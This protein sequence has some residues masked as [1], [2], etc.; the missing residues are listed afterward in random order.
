[1]NT[2]YTQFSR[3]ELV[4]DFGRVTDY[5]PEEEIT[6]SMTRLW[7]EAATSWADEVLTAEVAGLSGDAEGAQLALQ[8][9]GRIERQW[10][11]DPSTRR[12]VSL[13]FHAGFVSDSSL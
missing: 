3:S 6:P 9:A 11:D 13:F 12:I 1:M 8:R 4:T 10:G 7:D 2:P 5:Y